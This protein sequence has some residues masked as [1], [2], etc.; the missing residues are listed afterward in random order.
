MSSKIG[1]VGNVV[2]AGTELFRLVRQGRLEWRPELDA[3][4]IASVKAG[5]KAELTLPDGERI[6]GTVCVAA[7]TLSTSTGR[8]MV[9]VDLADVGTARAGMFASGLIRLGTASAITLPQTA[10]V[11]RDGR[12]YV[13]LVTPTTRSPRPDRAHHRHECRAHDAGVSRRQ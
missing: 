1:I 3:R 13:Y 6:D 7:P 11:M 8:A 4:A 9:Y 10:I 12:A 2:S 5:Q